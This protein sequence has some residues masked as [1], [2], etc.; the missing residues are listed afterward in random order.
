MSDL[1]IGLGQDCWRRISKF[2]KKPTTMKKIQ[3]V[4]YCCLAA[5]AGSSAFAVPVDYPLA[6]PSFES[7]ALDINNTWYGGVSNWGYTGSLGT[8][9]SAPYVSGY[10]APNGSQFLY[11][12]ADD[13]HIFQQTGT[14][15][16]NTRYWMQV[17]LYL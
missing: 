10:P 14:I 16:A 7:P 17:S 2:V 12:A 11:G 8:T 6:N 15:Q 5:M 1:E 9:F 13:W 3:N 4:I